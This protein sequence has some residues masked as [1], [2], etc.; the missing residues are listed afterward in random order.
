MHRIMVF[1]CGLFVSN[2]TRSSGTSS[3]SSSSSLSNSGSASLSSLSSPGGLSLLSS[4][5]SKLGGS[6]LSSSWPNVSEWSVYHTKVIN[7]ISWDLMFS[8]SHEASS[9]IRFVFRNKPNSMTIVKYAIHKTMQVISWSLDRSSMWNTQHNTYINHLYCR[10][11]LLG[12]SCFCNNLCVKAQ[13]QK[14]Y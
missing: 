6:S 12:G 5:V 9:I 1:L 7:C 13:L 8:S 10:L 4:S 3:E 11:M 14:K 2:H